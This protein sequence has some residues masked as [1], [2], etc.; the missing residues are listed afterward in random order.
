VAQLSSL[1]IDEVREAFVDALQSKTPFVVSAPTGSGKSTRLPLWMAEVR[2]RCVVVEPR[3]MACRSLA[4][5]LA[6]ASDE[7]VGESVGLCM[8]GERRMGPSTKVVFVT[9]GVALR[10]LAENDPWMDTVLVDEFH[11]R[12]AEVDIVVAAL[13]ERGGVWGVTSATL[14][15]D[16]WTTTFDAAGIVSEGRMHPVDVLHDDDT[17]KPSRLNLAERVADTVD[18][19]LLRIDDGDVLVFLPGMRDLQDARAACRRL[20]D[21]HNVDVLLAHSSLPQ[22]HMAKLFAPA[23]RRRVLLATNVAE[24][25]V[26]FPRVRVVVDSGLERRVVHRGGRAVLMTQPI[27][28]ASAVQRAG[29]AGRVGPGWCWR[30]YRSATALDDKTPPE[31][32][33][34]PLDDV[35]PKAAACGLSLV[36]ATSSAWP[37]P[38]PE[39]AFAE[40]KGRLIDMGVVDD[41]GQLTSLGQKAARF[42]VG[43]VLAT[44]LVDAPSSSAW[45]LCGLVALLDRGRSVLRKTY[46]EDELRERATQFEGLPDVWCELWCVDAPEAKTVGIDDNALREVRQTAEALRQLVGAER[47]PWTPSPTSELLQ[48]MVARWPQWCFGRRPRRGK[49]GRVGREAYTNGVVE[50]VVTPEEAAWDDEE[51]PLAP[52]MLVLQQRWESERDGRAPRGYGSWGLPLSQDDVVRVASIGQASEPTSTWKNDQLWVEEVVKLGDAELGRRRRRAS[53]DEVRDALV[54]VVLQRKAHRPVAEA[55]Q[56]AHRVWEAS[57]WWDKEE[58]PP[59]METWVRMRMELLGVDEKGDLELLDASDWVGDLEKVSGVP[60]WEEEGWWS[61]FP[62]TWTY[63]GGVFACA[64]RPEGVVLLP[65]DAK[66]KKVKQ[67]PAA[68]VPR[69]R[70]KPVFHQQASRKVRLR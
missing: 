2:G 18:N 7:R 51:K 35:L 53:V 14:G 20:Q 4:T 37:S 62:T 44:A 25:S 70:G 28:E 63:E 21:V 67:L 17:A 33:R 65:R 41:T 6:A 8:R 42:P 36:S 12:S 26:T 56:R 39:Q 15:Q 50:L 68:K 69:F 16:D 5:F 22:S 23:G 59:A 52:L 10:M 30:M 47:A 1:P 66:A 61:D 19:A 45:P 29:R 9:P 48:H 60:S 27:S 64:L 54:D 46:D 24:T 34:I 40:A 55:L 43:I 49:G 11:E 38:L 32:E 3:R 13:R 31:V 57:A 58:A